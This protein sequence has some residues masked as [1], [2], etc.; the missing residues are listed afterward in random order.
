MRRLRDRP[1]LLAAAYRP[2]DAPA[3]L[4]QLIAGWG[5]EGVTRRLPLARLTADEAL[6][7]AEANLAGGEHERL[8]AW[9][10]RLRQARS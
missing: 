10:G 1:L 7:R 4:A 3:A 8:R 2:E 9:A 5:R 6:R